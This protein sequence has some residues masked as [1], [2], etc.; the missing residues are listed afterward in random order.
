MRIVCDAVANRFAL[1]PETKETAPTK[2]L[3]LIAGAG[4]IFT[5]DGHADPLDDGRDM[6]H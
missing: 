1:Q 5:D 3:N 2:G 4:L 6:S